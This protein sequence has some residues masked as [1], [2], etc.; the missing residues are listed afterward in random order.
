[1]SRPLRIEFSGAWYYVM[2]RDVDYRN[3]FNNDTHRMIFVKVLGTHLKPGPKSK[4]S[5]SLNCFP[6]STF[7]NV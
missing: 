7:K 1:M 6:S 2:N 4:I 5:S 3:I